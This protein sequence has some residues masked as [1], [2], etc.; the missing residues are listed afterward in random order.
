[1]KRILL[2]VLGLAWPAVAAAQGWIEPPPGRR[3]GFG[4]EKVRTSVVA[5]VTGRVAQVEVEEWFKNAGGALGEGDYLYPLP[6]EA[7]FSSY[8]LFQGDEELRGETMDANQA[9]AIYEEIVRRKRD[10]ALIELAGHGLIRARVFPIQPGETRKITLRFTQ[11]LDRAGD[12]LQFRYAAGRPSAPTTPIPV[13]DGVTHPSEAVPLDF[14]LIADSASRFRDP[15][16]PTHEVRVT[17][18][19]GRLTVRPAGH[20]RGDFS[21]VLPFARPVVGVSLLAHRPSGEDGYFMLTL[22]PG[23][24]RGPG[25]PRDIAV[26]LDVSGSMSGSKLVQAK[27]ALHQLLGTIGQ[28]DRFRLIAFSNGVSVERE[29]WARP[30]REGLAAARRWIDD[31]QAEGG[32]NIAGALDEAF[33]LESAEGRLPIVVFVTDGLP[34]VG[35]QNPERIAARAEERRGRARVFTFGVGHDVNTYL[36][37]RLSSAARGATAYVEPGEDVERALGM[38]A[39]KIERPVLADLAIEQ[40]PGVLEEIYPETLPD[41]FAGDELV[42]F[43]RYRAARG[44]EREALV[45]RG[46]R[47]GHTERFSADVELPVHRLANDFIPR[48]WAS[49]KLGALSQRVRLNGHDAEL[50]DEI[51]R[52][53][54]RYGLLSEYTSYLVQEPMAVAEADRRQVGGS[55]GLFRTR[56]AAAAPASPAAAVGAEAVT[57]AKEEQA[58][59]DAR[60]SVQLNAADEI[61]LERAEFGQARHVAGRLFRQMDGVWTDLA[62]RDSTRLVTVEPFSAAYFMVLRVLPELGV[63]VQ[64]FPQ[65]EVGGERAR[66][67]VASGGATTLESDAVARLVR[68]FRGQ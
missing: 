42:I 58:R 50:V 22:S 65:V 56:D 60:S 37:D 16:S 62:A 44:P 25:L 4:V 46:T 26:V 57:R 59:R 5:R 28:G 39:S 21:L 29:G 15:F 2:A 40:A 14:T 30:T 64:E 48:L 63:Y 55:R 61:L 10:P 6:G 8:S 17:R 66:V 52:T 27:A 18:Q 24:A 35:E 53:A 51:R 34:S 38:L 11:V 41:L 23:E 7:V 32:T 20:L 47:N 9:R 12:A 3:G 33:R 19:A 36:L 13:R 54:L 31:L 43:G 45:I 1:M 67:R 49:R 68:D